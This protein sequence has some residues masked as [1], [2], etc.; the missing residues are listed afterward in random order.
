MGVSRSALPV[1]LEKTRAVVSECHS[2]SRPLH[3]LEKHNILYMM[4]LDDSGF[5]V[6][7]KTPLPLKKN[8]PLAL[9]ISFDPLGAGETRGPPCPKTSS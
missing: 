8:A 3:R 6:P 1:L 5:K 4:F 2:G 9:L 7:W